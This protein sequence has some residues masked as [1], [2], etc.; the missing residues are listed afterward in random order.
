MSV[1]YNTNKDVW[2]FV[3]NEEAQVL[4]NTM[5][6]MAIMSYFMVKSIMAWIFLKIIVI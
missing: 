6:I 4:S 3:E 2:H 5:A 1:L